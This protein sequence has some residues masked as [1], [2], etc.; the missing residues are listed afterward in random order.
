M[1]F[2][3]GTRS[4]NSLWFQLVLITFNYINVE[5]TTNITIIILFICNNNY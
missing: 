1:E 5:I 2:L 3:M 4:G